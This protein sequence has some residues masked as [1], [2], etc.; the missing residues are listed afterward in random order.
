M[1]MTDILCNYQTDMRR[2]GFS[3]RPTTDDW[4]GTFPDG[5]VGIALL[6]LTNHRY[7]IKHRVCVWGTDDLGMEIDVTSCDE[8]RRIILS[9]PSIITMNDLL[10]RGFYWA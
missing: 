5:T 1:I 6:S 10:G 9:L 4:A 7:S 3:F 8:A 2:R